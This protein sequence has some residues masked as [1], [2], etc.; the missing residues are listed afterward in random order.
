MRPESAG[1]A[2]GSGLGHTPEMLDLQVE[3]IEP[4]DELD[5]R[6]GASTDDADGCSKFP[7]ARVFFKRF[8]D[9]D[10]HGGDTASDSYLFTD[11]QAKHAFGIYVRTGEY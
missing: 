6:R 7:A 11:H 2:D 5:R 1:S 10:P 8:K 9:G 3:V 4:A